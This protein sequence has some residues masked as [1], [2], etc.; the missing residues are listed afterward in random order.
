MPGFMGMRGLDPKNPHDRERER[1]EENK[2]H[3]HDSM[4]R[5]A[6]EK[7]HEILRDQQGDMSAYSGTVS[8]E[9]QGGSDC[10]RICNFKVGEI[11]SARVAVL[12]F[13]D[14]L[15]TVHGIFSKVKFRHLPVV[16]DDGTIIGILSDRDF[17]R[18]ESP[19][20]GT[21]NEQTRDKEIMA[22]KVGTVMT[23]NPICAYVDTSIIEA[24]RLMNDRKISCLPI[25]ERGTMRLLGIVTWKDVVRAFCPLAFSHQR[26]SSRLKSGVK[27]NPQ[28]AESARL[29]ARSN[30]S[31]RLRARAEGPGDAR[32]EHAPPPAPP[33]P[34]HGQRPSRSDTDHFP[35]ADSPKIAATEKLPSGST[36]G[37]AGSE[38]AA[39]QKA[40]LREQLE[41]TTDSARLR[42]IRDEQLRRHRE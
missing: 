24:V 11:M 2:A 5:R 35:R 39:R 16:E 40:L 9:G 15:L 41:R 34:T 7:V 20:F 26:D 6:E 12:S 10:E 21:V 14:N 31:A 23:R 22:R 36:A 13:D 29:R 27:I 18:H 25:A 8:R 19:F 33:A 32:P 38:L 1:R 3:N 4:E 30:E 42:A 17:L 37:Q 28:S